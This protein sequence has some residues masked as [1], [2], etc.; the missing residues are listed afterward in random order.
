MLKYLKDKGV[1]WFGRDT[2]TVNPC[3]PFFLLMFQFSASDA[4]VGVKI[5]FVVSSDETNNGFKF[6][7]KYPL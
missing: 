4:F 7:L 3:V 6:Q 1:L 5:D 2:G